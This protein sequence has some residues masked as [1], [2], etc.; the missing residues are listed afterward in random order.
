MKNEKQVLTLPDV[1]NY[2]GVH[3][4]TIYKFAQKGE[5]P[6]FKVGSNWRFQ[7]K[8]IDSWITAQTNNHKAK[9]K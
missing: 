5:I 7:K 6:A 8:D 3:R 2:L 4:A 9:K 1:A